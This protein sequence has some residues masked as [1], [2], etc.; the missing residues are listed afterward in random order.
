MSF[1]NEF[2]FLIPSYCAYP[3]LFPLISSLE[4]IQYVDLC[5]V[6]SSLFIIGISKILID[7]I[8][9]PAKCK[10]ESLDWMC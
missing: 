4:K 2:H 5:E 6:S 10:S 3:H 8:F 1:V 9:S 7:Q